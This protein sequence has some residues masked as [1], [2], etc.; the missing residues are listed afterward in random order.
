MKLARILL[1]ALVASVVF[2]QQPGE[3]RTSFEIRYVTEGSVYINGGR[4]EGLQEGFRLSV[5]RLKPGEPT[6]SAEPIGELIV[7]AVTA[8]S[9]VCDIEA[10]KMDLQVGDTAQISRAD[11]ETMQVIQQSKT[12]RRYAQVVSFAGADPLDQELRDYIPKPPSPEINRIRGRVA[13]EFGALR[14]DGVPPTIQN[15][16]LL[17]MDANRIGGTFW[18][19]TGYWRGRITSRPQGGATPLTMYDLLNRT[20]HIG[21]YYANPQSKHMMGLGRLFVPWAT[22]LST[23][24]GGYYGRRLTRRMTFGAFGGSTP[25]PTAWDYK[26]DR[27]IG[28]VFEN[29]DIGSFENLRFNQTVGVAMTRLRWQA[30]REYLFTESNLSWKQKVAIYNNLQAD[31]L[32]PGR[33]GNTENGVVLSRSFLTV[34]YQPTRWLS[35]DL[36][37]NYFRTI[38]TFD[39]LLVGTGLLDK[40]LF[41]GISGGMRLE[42]PGQVALYG[43]VGQSKRNDDAR[44]SLNQ[45]YGISVRNVLGTGFRGDVR[46]SI[47]QGAFGNGWYQSVGFGRD[48]SDRLRFDFMAGQQE[49]RSSLTNSVRGFFVNTNIDW[50][51]TRHYS[52]GGGINLFRGSAQ[53]Y[54]QTYFSL[55]YVF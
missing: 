36:N 13:Y 51:I 20:Y 12:A 52:L 6:L 41:D 21:A 16:M 38:P 29:M 15:G 33:L 47:F 46:R 2:A 7:T 8:H 11:L 35:L 54:D 43:N 42:L 1:L 24:D 10:S 14:N 28:G 25:D 22:S 26:P 55:G 5:K 39:F 4:D 34:R 30:E 17:R 27:Q 50:F 44:G 23:I 18:N 48:I 45:M 37:H 32:T 3:I 19:V 49:F 31:R 53:K 9:A 40:L